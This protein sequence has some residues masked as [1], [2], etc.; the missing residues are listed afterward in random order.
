[1]LQHAPFETVEHV[2][3]FVRGIWPG[4]TPDML[5]ADD[6]DDVDWDHLREEFN[7]V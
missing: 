1:M 7:E 2:Q 5:S 4:G 6:Y 3:N